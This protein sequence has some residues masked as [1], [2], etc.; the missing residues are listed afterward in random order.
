MKKTVYMNKFNAINMKISFIDKSKKM[1]KKCGNDMVF[2][3]KKHKMVQYFIYY[4]DG[5]QKLLIFDWPSKLYPLSSGFVL[6]MYK[7]DVIDNKYRIIVDHVSNNFDS[8]H[9]IHF[10]LISSE[11][12]KIIDI[13]TMCDNE[14][15]LQ[16]SKIT[17]RK[18][19]IFLLDYYKMKQRSKNIQIRTQ[20][21]RIPNYSDIWIK[22]QK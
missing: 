15:D 1:Y 2:I 16:I 22:C 8:L 14:G 7:S 5:I 10:D 19:G 9:V 17:F 4:I 21:K 6:L 13:R 18:H 11:W 12:P 20:I 3:D